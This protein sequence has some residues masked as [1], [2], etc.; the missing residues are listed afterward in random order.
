MSRLL[1]VLLAL[2]VIV[3]YGVAEGLWTNRWHLSNE[4]ELAGGRLARLPLQ[5]GD[6]EGEA[7]VLDPEQVAKGEITGYLMRRYVHRPSGAVVSVLFVVGR[8]GPIAAHP[9]E[10]CYGGAGYAQEGEAVR[11]HVDGD[12][13]ADFWVGHFQKNS[14]VPEQLRIAWSWTATGTWVAADNPMA[15][16][17]ADPVLYKLYVVRQVV[18]PGAAPAQEP[19]TEF[20]KVFL[21]QVR[22]Y[23]FAGP[24]R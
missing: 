22:E 15:A 1:P 23:L 14:A 9:P 13:P 4:A 20:L 8:P 24:G 11:E 6:W 2:P 12:P 3:A 17:A 18:G 7:Q 19:A 21:P 10:V 16:F 5:V